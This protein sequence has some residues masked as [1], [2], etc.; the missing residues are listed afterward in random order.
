LRKKA[1]REQRKEAERA[2]FLEHHQSEKL[3]NPRNFLKGWLKKQSNLRK[4]QE[5]R[6]LKGKQKKK[7]LT[8]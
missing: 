2:A 3:K 4:L 7:K 1:A 6:L 8:R 5:K